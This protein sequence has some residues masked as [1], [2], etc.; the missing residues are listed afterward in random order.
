[1]RRRCEMLAADKNPSR[2]LRTQYNSLTLWLKLSRGTHG[3]AVSQSK[4]F[5]PPAEN[6]GRLRPCDR[7]VH[8]VSGGC[9]RRRPSVL[10]GIAKSYIA[11]FWSNSV[12]FVLRLISR[13]N[14]RL[15]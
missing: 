12:T 13:L 4:K 15:Q 7:P 9:E 2:R 10:P 5:V 1:M 6:F 8:A 14:S 11:I 3:S